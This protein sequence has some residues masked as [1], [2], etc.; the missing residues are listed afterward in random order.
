MYRNNSHF[1]EGIIYG[2]VKS[3]RLGSSLG[4]NILPVGCKVCSLNCTYCQYGWTDVHTIDKNE[5]GKV[6]LPNVQEVIT[7]IKEIL[8]GIKTP[9]DCLTFSGYGEPTLHPQFN[10]IIKQTKDLRDKYLNERNVPQMPI[11]IISN[12]TNIEKAREG[13]QIADIRMMKLDACEENVFNE[14]NKPAEGVTLD[15]IVKNL[16]TLKDIIIQSMF[17]ETNASES[18]VEKWINCI[19]E[20]KP[21]EVQI[22]T[23]DR[24]PADL[25]LKALD[26]SVLKDIACKLTEKTGIKVTAF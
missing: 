5:L 13:L 17:L 18:A 2:P 9:I 21:L 23:L 20:I 15:A 10:E 6:K 3:R 25:N 11:I 22:Y 19:A 1:P 26:K 14:I 4:I 24:P 8:Y 16:K 12:S 7:A